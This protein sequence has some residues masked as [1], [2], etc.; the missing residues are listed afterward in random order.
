MSTAHRPGGLPIRGS[1]WEPHQSQR[2]TGQRRLE[3]AAAAAAVV[4]VTSSTSIE[5]GFRSTQYVSTPD[6][7]A[8]ATCHAGPSLNSMS[9]LNSMS[10]L[11]VT[12]RR[13][14]TSST[15]PMNL[16]NE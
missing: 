9:T 1:Q 12:V 8:R 15:L 14:L 6:V 16:H 2:P 13:L 11:S 10:R 5:M 7:S 4:V 3:L